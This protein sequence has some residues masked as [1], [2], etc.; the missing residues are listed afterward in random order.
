LI[1]KT[2]GSTG[3]TTA[4][5]KKGTVAA[6]INPGLDWKG[7]RNNGGHTQTVALLPG[8]QAVDK[9]TSASLAGTLTSDQRGNGFPRTVNKAATN[10]SGGDGTDIGAFELQ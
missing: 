10:A 6:P 3:F 2:D 5:D 4:T 8:S 7:L 9:G 1:G